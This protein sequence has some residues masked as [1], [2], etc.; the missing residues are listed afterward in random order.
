MVPPLNCTL[1]EYA[2]DINRDGHFGVE[3]NAQ[4]RCRPLP[5]GKAALG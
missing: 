2:A 5:C 1:N 3:V 4:K